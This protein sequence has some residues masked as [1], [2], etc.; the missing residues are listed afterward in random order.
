MRP[1]IAQMSKQV[2]GKTNHLNKTD[3]KKSRSNQGHC[4]NNLGVHLLCSWPKIVHTSVSVKNINSFSIGRAVTSD[5][6][7]ERNKS[8]FASFTSPFI[9]L[10]GLFIIICGMLDYQSDETLN[11]GSVCVWSRCWWDVMPE[12]GHSFTAFRISVPWFCRNNVT[13]IMQ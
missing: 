4:F 12:F 10:C 13:S 7:M 11:G 2:R 5:I 8:W 6:N 1:W 9:I 3:R